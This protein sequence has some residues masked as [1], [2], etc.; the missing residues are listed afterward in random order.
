MEVNHDIRLQNPA[1]DEFHERSKMQA[2]MDSEVKDYRSFLWDNLLDAT[3]DERP[4]LPSDKTS[5][6]ES[7]E[8][9]II[10]LV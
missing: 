7:E 3:I 1:Y 10:T 8:T 5:D 2:Q 4:R 9:C 6:E